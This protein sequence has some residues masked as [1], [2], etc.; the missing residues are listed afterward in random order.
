M[1]ASASGVVVVASIAFLMFRFLGD[2]IS[3]LLPEDATVQD[4]AEMREKLGLNDPVLVQYGRFIADAAQGDF[5][6]SYRNNRPVSDL[7]AE[8]FP[9]TAELVLVAADELAK[10]EEIQ[11][12]SIV[13][14]LD[15]SQMP[16][17]PSNK[18]LKLSVLLAGVLGVGLG[19]LLG[20]V[21]SYVNN[22]DIDE[23]RKLRRVRNFLKKKRQAMFFKLIGKM[24]KKYLMLLRNQKE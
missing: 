23:R 5:G 17:G 22:S 11:V 2:P 1:R 4:R 16:L 20:F 8:R 13:Q 12:A 6:Q 10:I 24:K 18:N 3:N 7:L 15:E 19:I 21:R 14:V 9:A